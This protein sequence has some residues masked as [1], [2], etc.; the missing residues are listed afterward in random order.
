M[1]GKYYCRIPIFISF[2]K[3]IDTKPTVLIGACPYL[4][5]LPHIGIYVMF[6]KFQNSVLKAILALAPTASLNSPDEL[7]RLFFCPGFNLFLFCFFFGG[8]GI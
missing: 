2:F 4:L 7:V 8:T 1:K 5:F 3:N 6:E